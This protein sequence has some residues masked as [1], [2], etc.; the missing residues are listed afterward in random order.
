MRDLSVTYFVESV[1]VEAGV[2]WS[3][4]RWPD[5]DFASTIL[6]VLIGGVEVGGSVLRFLLERHVRW[7]VH[8]ARCKTVTWL[9]ILQTKNEKALEN[10]QNTRSLF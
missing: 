8:A 3:Q 2:V 10:I 6:A 1:S 9:L 7:L 5:H 4:V